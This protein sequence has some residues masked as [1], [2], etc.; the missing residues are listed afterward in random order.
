MLR[1][2]FRSCRVLVLACTCCTG[3]SDV[4]PHFEVASVKPAPDG[5]GFQSFSG[6]PGSADPERVTWERTPLQILIQAAYHLEP[7]QIS[8]PS[9][10]RTERYSVIAKLPS[11]STRS[12][13]APMLASLLAVRFG[14]VCHSVTKQFPGYEIGLVPGRRPRLTPSPLK[15]DGEP[16]FRGERTGD[17]VMHYTFTQTS[18]PLLADRLRLMIPRRGPRQPVQIAPVN[19]GTGLSGK[20]DFTLDIAEPT[21]FKEEGE[22]DVEDNSGSMADALQSQLGLKLNHVKVELGVLVIDHVERV[23]TPN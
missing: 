8:G 4:S 23:P 16:I 13:L 19:D 1:N 7:Y 2:I 12:Q 22:N 9:W 18:M 11:G 5:Q 14:L 21:S 20:F 15:A 3:Q 17:G 10:I 6:G